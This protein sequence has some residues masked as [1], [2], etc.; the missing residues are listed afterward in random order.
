MIRVYSHANIMLAYNMKN[1]LEREGIKCEVRN[2]LATS[3]AGEV[4]PIEVWPE[5]LVDEADQERAEAIVDKALL[6]FTPTNWNQSQIVTITAVDEL[7]TDG[8][9]SLT[10][11][12]QIDVDQ[13]DDAFDSVVVQTISLTAADN[14]FG[15][16]RGISFTDANHNGSRDV[17]E[18]VL[19]GATIFLD[20]NNNFILD[21]NETS[22]TT[23]ANGE[24]EF[25]AVPIGE[26]I[27]RQVA[28]QDTVQTAPILDESYYAFTYIGGG[29]GLV[30]PAII[31]PQSGVVRRIGEPGPERLH[32]FVRTNSGEYFGL[33]GLGTDRFLSLNIA[34]NDLF[35]IGEIGSD[36]AFGLAY[37]PSNDIIYGLVKDTNDG[38]HKLASFDRTTGTPTLIGPGTDQLQNASGLAFDTDR[39]VIVAFDNN[40]DQFWQFDASGVPTL[41]WETSGI[42]GWG[43]SQDGN[44]SFLLHAQTAPESAPSELHQYFHRVDPFAQTILHHD[45]VVSE[46]VPLDAFDYFRVDEAHLVF[47]GSDDD[48]AGLNFGTA[49][50]KFVITESD[51]ST[52]VSETASTDTIDVVLPFKPQS[53]VTL[54]ISSGDPQ[55]VSV[56]PTTL[57]FTPANFNTRQT[58]TAT[59]VDDPTVDGQQVT[60]ITISVDATTSDDAFDTV[61]NQTVFVTTADDD[62]AGFS[63]VESDLNTIV[64]ET[65]ATNS[66]SVVLTRQPL[67][68]V[69]ILVTNS[70][71]N[72]IS[73]DQTSLTFTNSNWDTA[74]SVLV[75]GLDD[76]LLDGTTVSTIS[77]VV[78]TLNSDDAFDSLSAQSIDVSNTDHETLTLVFD[79]NAISE[80]GGSATGTVTR[81][82]I[83][84]GS[85]LVVALTNSDSTGATTP[86]TVTIPAN[87]TFVTFDLN[88]VEDTILDGT[89]TVLVAAAATGYV[90]DSATIDVL[91]HETLTLTINADSISENG[92][93]TTA[94]ITRNNINIS[95]ALTV[96]L[97]NSDPSEASVPT[98]VT[99]FAGQAS[100]VFSI[101]AWHDA[102]LDGTQ[103]LTLTASAIGYIGSSDTIEVT[104]YELL[105]VDISLPLLY[106]NQGTRSATVSRTNSDKSDPLMVM[107]TSSDTTE[108]TVPDTVTIPA[109]ETSTTFD[110][111]AVDDDL[112]D[113]SQL[114][115]IS[116]S[117]LGYF[118]GTDTIEVRDHEWLTVQIDSAAISERNGLTTATISRS[119]TDI[120][121][122]LTVNLWSSDTSEATVPST[123]TIPAGQTSTPFD[124]EAVDDNSLD[125]T[126]TVLVRADSDG[127]VGGSDFVGVTDYEPLT[128]QIDP[129]EIT[130]NGG[131]ASGTVSRNNEGDLSQPLTV[132]LTTSDTTEATVVPTVT[133]AAN[134]R[135]ATFVITAIDDALLDGTKTVTVTSSASGYASGNALLGVTDHGTLTITITA[136]AIREN[137]GSTT[138]TVTRSNTADLSQSLVVSL[139]S[140]DTTE[141]NVPSNISINAGSDS[142]TFS[143]TGVDDKTLD[144]PQT[145]TI[146]STAIGFLGASDTLDVEDHETLT[147][148]FDAASINE[149]GGATSTT[150]TRSNT[151][152]LS[153]P[154]VVFL[155][156]SDMTEAIVP[157]SVTIPAGQTT[158]TFTVTAE[159]DKVLDGTVTSV[160]TASAVGF[161]D[162]RADL[163]V[164]DFERIALVIFEQSISEHL[165]TATGLVARTNT[166][167]GTPQL[168]TLTNFNPTAVDIP[169]SLIIPA[170]QNSVTFTISAVDDAILDG[171]QTA[172]ITAS[173]VGYTGSSHT[174]DV[175]DHE[176]LSVSIDA[177]AISENG[178]TATGTVSRSN[179]DD[180]SQILLVTLASSDTSEVT[181]PATVTVDVNQTSASFTITAVDDNILDGTHTATITAAASGYVRG[182]DSIDVTD[183][184]TLTLTI[185]AASLNE[186]GGSTTAT[187]TRSNTD[188]SQALTVT[189][190]S[191][192][193]SEATV[194][195]TV[196]I[197]ANRATATFTINAVDD[198]LL[199][200]TQTVTITSNASGYFPGQDTFDVT[201]HES[202]SLVIDTSSISENGGTAT[203]TITRH[204][205]DTTSPLVVTLASNNTSEATVTTSVTIAAN[206]ASATFIID[207]VDDALLD[208]TQTVEIS[209]SHGSYAISANDT[210]DVTDYETLSLTIDSSAISENGETATATVSRSNTDVQSA[211]FVT[212]ASTPTG[213]ATI[214]TGITIPANQQSASFTISATDNDILDSSRSI[215]V[216]ATHASYAASSNDS[217]DITDH[218]TL[219]LSV[220][221]SV[222]LENGGLAQGTV[223]RLN[224]DIGQPLIVTLNSSDTTEA[225][226]PAS[227]TIAADETSATFTISAVDDNLLD[228]QQTV[229]ITASAPAFAESGI[230]SVSVLDYETLVI[231]FDTDSIS[232]RGG[233]ATATLTRSNTDTT[234]P[235][236]VNLTSSDT[237]K[238]TVPISVTIPANENSATFTVVAQDDNLLDGTASVNINA[239][240]AGY[241]ANASSIA[242][243]DA[244]QL[245]LTIASSSEPELGGITTATVSR[246]TT[247]D[248]SRVLVVRLTS[249][250]T[251]EAT[252]P[253]TVTIP[254][255]QASATFN[256]VTVDDALLDGTQSVQVTATATG[257][258]DGSDS[259]DI[260][261]HETLTLLLDTTSLSENNGTATGTVVR[262][263]LDDLAQSLVISLGSNDTSEATVPATVTIA[264]NESFATF[265]ISAVDDDLL[266]GTQTIEISVSH[267]SYVASATETLDVKDHET[268]TVTIDADSISENGGMATG[269]VTRSNADLGSEVT[270]TLTNSDATELSIPVEVTILAN[271][272]SASFTITAVDDNILD[273]PQ[274]VDISASHASY[275]GLANGSIVTSDHET[276]MLSLSSVEI[277][278]PSGEATLTVTRQDSSIGQAL[279]VQLASNDETEAVLPSSIT[280]P[281]NET[282]AT[283][284]I[285]AQA[286]NET[287][288]SQ[289][290]EI[291]ADA[292]GYATSTINI[293]IADNARA[294]TNPDLAEDVNDDEFVSPVDALI[295]INDLNETGPR[296]LPPGGGESYLD[297]SEDGSVSAIDVLLVINYLNEPIN[298]GEGE[299]AEATDLGDGNLD[300]AMLNDIAAAR[301]SA[302]KSQQTVE[303]SGSVQKA[304]H[305]D[306]QP[307]ATLLE[308]PSVRDSDRPGVKDEAHLEDV[309]NDFA[310]QVRELWDS[311]DGN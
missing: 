244:E 145:V 146:T 258:D 102:L 150:V 153:E 209:A 30:Q 16:I 111:S 217:I 165:G 92:G 137:G 207:A 181:V 169:T 249:N 58:I 42:T 253:A 136:D 4:P 182:N 65:G 226:V 179:T 140:S 109:G 105:P 235:L 54:T 5:V 190:A 24:Y 228:G 242:V 97:A 68:D 151:D 33:N 282:S 41:L 289:T 122:P 22:T 187:I 183:H 17:G 257:F 134:E 157:A 121:Q 256:I 277:T 114:V 230:A 83:D 107:L 120:D 127:Y 39:G 130:E 186:S 138:A 7:Q 194:P 118:A 192:D 53:N 299:A 84:I 117:A 308:S 62:V 32:G 37:D 210:L 152:D 56:S 163:H 79:A 31:D 147:L 185:D 246:S 93:G 265:P 274:V 309:I 108:A 167:I 60:S 70:N 211:L 34:S 216:S 271:Q 89:Q 11:T 164:T 236:T 35:E 284:T 133:I 177:A 302:E 139:A 1:L 224:S 252:V 278:E 161:D 292:D 272:A 98:S 28:P 27:V 49:R 126:K 52:S 267:E 180:L 44:G 57:T 160:I 171:T 176:T 170:D 38:L 2:D 20:Q 227:V 250:D 154:L 90:G 19:I 72:E 18:P 175:T 8:D 238:A 279:T 158:T 110:I 128:V 239:T 73:V 232:E 131:T 276:L 268:L 273:G 81:S 129:A 91:D 223:S 80:N 75:T 241:F 12:F 251:S 188:T 85:E 220:D 149:N 103:T 48:V 3:T 195:A 15:D 260:T 281:A 86:V 255:D 67:S 51:G 64:S 172:F 123:V 156:S 305:F 63:V 221:T 233:T 87:E 94:T 259:L 143:I 112:L 193:Q 310:E 144:G 116:A 202:I 248:L 247:D 50:G 141:V 162:G 82:N 205:T 200:G 254:T 113:G 96:T 234:S 148:E 285:I 264:A 237:T 100:R 306:E 294:W 166:D 191:N 168:V 203:G 174:I 261:D 69:T 231:T 287:D 155:S 307:V 262:S 78:D 240:A 43:L 61:A 101:N 219:T 45:F 263:N 189:I 21:G 135:S 132:T 14:D 283:A 215:L 300:V 214:P 104:D 301:H 199:D 13:S 196:T 9:Q 173:A 297:V 204:N 197:P 288:G 125:G 59:G 178:G 106:E 26:Y 74:Q 213:E 46:P 270:V 159:D 201:D 40:D 25:L 36:A 291:S 55:E 115:T 119:N 71:D 66:F 293:N 10:L 184:E 212:I 296:E 99:I 47:V 88:A 243:N 304:A 29:T 6:T 95:Q 142:A 311:F 229:S 206:E 269:T 266:D 208:G 225:T 280:I 77:L 290:V 303:D 295:V 286:D 76:Q 275:S 124:I 218:E 198:D 298:G 245:S 222:M 23:N